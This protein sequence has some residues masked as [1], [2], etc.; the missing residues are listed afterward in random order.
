V[1]DTSVWFNGQTCAEAILALGAGRIDG[2]WS[3]QIVRELTRVRL[4]VSK[5]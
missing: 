2:Y 4:C 5:L 1:I 3:A